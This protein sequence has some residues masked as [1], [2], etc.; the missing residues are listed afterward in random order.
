LRD[1]A[2]LHGASTVSQVVKDFPELAR[3]L[4]RFTLSTRQRLSRSLVDALRGRRNSARTIL[5]D[6]V[7]DGCR[8]LRTAGLNDQTIKE[9]FGALVEE[10]GRA[11][12]ADRPSLLSGDLRWM[13]VRAR[14]LDLVNAALDLA[15]T[16]PDLAMDHV[17]GPP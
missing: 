1:I 4:N 2:D 8:E 5:D 14:V 10:T 13:P 16:E 11:C 7:G 9:F 15:P 17:N 12:G 3:R 6:A